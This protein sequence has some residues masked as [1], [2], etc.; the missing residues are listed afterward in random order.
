M[1]KLGDLLT[2]AWRLYTKVV[3]SVDGAILKPFI[4]TST[5]DLRSMVHSLQHCSITGTC[6]RITATAFT[7][8]VMQELCFRIQ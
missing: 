4:I 5:Q 1:P 8:L 7:I 6:I 3:D 2:T